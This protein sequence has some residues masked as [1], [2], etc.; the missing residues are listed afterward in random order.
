MLKHVRRVVEVLKRIDRDND[1]HPFTCTRAENAAIR[2][3]MA[4]RLL[5]SFLQHRRANV[6]TYGGSDPV[7]GEFY[8]TK[9]KP[10]SKVEHNFVFQLLPTLGSNYPDYLLTIVC[11]YS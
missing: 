8:D 7:L 2:D 11:M 10:A 3:L 1:I 6:Q 5:A 4:L 9:T